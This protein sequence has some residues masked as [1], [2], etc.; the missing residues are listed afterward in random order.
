MDFKRINSKDCL[1]LMQNNEVTVIDIR[2]LN[3]F[4]TGHISEA[5]HI[6]EINIDSF[7]Q[8][9]DKQAPLVICCYH[10]NSSLSAAQFFVEKSFTEVYS[11]DGGFAAWS[12]IND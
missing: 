9:H 6:D 4:Q 12:M 11:L 8:E 3:S 1:H 10:G 7:V 2:D 5:I